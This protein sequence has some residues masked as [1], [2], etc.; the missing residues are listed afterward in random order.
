MTTDH[1]KLH[2]RAR[3]AL[4][5]LEP[6]EQARVRDRLAM[7]SSIPP[8]EWP[9]DL[10]SRPSFDPSLY[11]VRVDDTWRL[12]IGDDDG[13]PVVQDIVHQGRLDFYTGNLGKN[14]H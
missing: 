7:L 3:W 6:D 5:G 14:S 10:V 1:L 2:R 11:L 13:W 9:V 12:L 8:S 4:Q